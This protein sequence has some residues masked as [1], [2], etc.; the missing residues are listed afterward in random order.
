MRIGPAIS[1]V[2]CAAG[3]AAGGAGAG[4]VQLGCS[5]DRAAHYCALF[6]EVLAQQRPG[7]ALREEA[8]PG[9]PELHLNVAEPGPIGV[10]AQLRWQAGD[11]HWH[12]GPQLEFST[13]DRKMSDFLAKKFLEKLLDL[14][15]IDLGF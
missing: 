6:H 3:L 9:Q 1:M 5:G 7:W 11:G 15:E 13:S 8:L 4:T 12:E 10:Q 2:F 14:S